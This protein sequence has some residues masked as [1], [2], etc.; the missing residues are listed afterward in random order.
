MTEQRND[1]RQRSLLRGIVYFDGRPFAHECLV[2]DISDNGARIAFTD[3]PPATADRLELQ[4][5]IKALR[6]HCRVAW[7]G[8]QELG[9]AFLDGRQGD[10]SPQ[11]MAERMARL[12]AELESLKQVVRALRRDSRSDTAA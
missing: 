8:E 6:H 4:V 2:R 10:Q 11:A 7:R 1:Q 9:V 12:E 5:P 3:L